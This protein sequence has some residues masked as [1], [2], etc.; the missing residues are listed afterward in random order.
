MGNN[1]LRVAVVGLGSGAE[2]V[3]IYL[4]HPD[5]ETVAICDARSDRLTRVGTGRAGPPRRRHEDA[6]SSSPQPQEK[7]HESSE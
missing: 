7:E 3:P 1:K 2:F 4:H 5:V 6:G